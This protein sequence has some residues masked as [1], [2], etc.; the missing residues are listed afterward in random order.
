M[1]VKIDSFLEILNVG[2][3]KFFPVIRET[4]KF[5]EDLCKYNIQ[6]EVSKEYIRTYMKIYRII[7]TPKI[8]GAYS[9]FTVYLTLL[10]LLLPGM[11]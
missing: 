6:F 5:F 1:D 2:I 10:T 7:Y 8:Q 3:E 11:W 4:L 9:H